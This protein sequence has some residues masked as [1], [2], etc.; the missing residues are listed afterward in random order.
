MSNRDP[1]GIDHSEYGGPVNTDVSY[2]RDSGAITYFRVK[3]GV[4][5]HVCRSGEVYQP[6]QT[7]NMPMKLRCL[8]CGT[9]APT[10]DFV[11]SI[12]TENTGNRGGTDE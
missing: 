1:D 5:C 12:D 4:T 9:M 11:Y 3:N 10:S 6:G 2:F 8:R 7:M